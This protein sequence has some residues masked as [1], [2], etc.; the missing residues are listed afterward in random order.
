MMQRGRKRRERWCHVWSGHAGGRFEPLR[1]IMRSQ[2]SSPSSRPSIA[3]SP[4]STARHPVSRDALVRQDR[5]G[6]NLERKGEPEKTHLV[7]GLLALLLR[8]LL[9]SAVCG[10]LRLALLYRR[11]REDPTSASG[12]MHGRKPTWERGGGVREQDGP[13]SSPFWHPPPVRPRPSRR[14]SSLPGP[15]P[16]RRRSRPP[17]A[18]EPRERASS[19]RHSCARAGERH[20]KER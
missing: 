20:T 17:R 18:C 9:G 16:L 11:E 15:Q 8:G 6:K 14:P 2:P 3:S 13:F 10:D 7:L 19:R 12:F 4:P 5:R 1:S